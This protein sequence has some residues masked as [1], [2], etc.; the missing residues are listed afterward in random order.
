MP[1]KEVKV[2]PNGKF[3]DTLGELIGLIILML[4][5]AQVFG[6][7]SGGIAS[8]FSNRDAEGG[9]AG[10]GISFPPRDSDIIFPPRGIEFAFPPST[11]VVISFPPEISVGSSVV[12]L[13]PATLYDGP[14]GNPVG[15]VPAGVTGEV[16]GGP[17]WVDGVKWWQVLYEN[18]QTGWVTDG[19][20]RSNDT[21]GALGE[22]VS[23]YGETTVY[24][25][26]GGVPIGTVSADTE[27]EIVGGPRD[28]NGVRYWEVV[29]D[30]G[31][32]GWVAE[33]DIRSIKPQVVHGEEVSAVSD[34][35]V[36]DRPGGRVIGVVPEGEVGEIVGGPQ[37]KNGVRYYEVQFDDGTRGWVKES[38]LVSTSSN[39]VLGITLETYESTPLYDKPGGVV[40]G[41]VPVNT[42]GTVIDGP[43][44]YAGERY[45]KME[46]ENGQTGWVAE[47][48]LMPSGKTPGI[49]ARITLARDT[50]VYVTPG[51]DV[52]MK[53]DKG[54][55][56]NIIAG[57]VDRD[58]VR[59]W[60]VRFDDG[61]EA[62][63]P[64]SAL[65]SAGGTKAWNWFMFSIKVVSYILIVALLSGIMYIFIRQSQL[66]KAEYAK[67]W[68]TTAPYGPEA[69]KGPLNP[70]WDKIQELMSSDNEN[71]WR[72]AIMNADIILDEMLTKM[73]YHG[74]SVGEKLKRIEPSDF[75]TLN[76]A[77]E[78]HTVR[79]M[80]AHEKNIILTRREAER[81]IALFKEVFSEFKLL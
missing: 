16:V 38:D 68:D 10:F 62:W 72:I 61:T 42:K 76:Q 46:F 36:Y 23:P 75:T 71:D 6:A 7:I 13:Q 60:K 28:V 3:H 22:K 67:Y 27:G 32:R 21:D 66:A 70:E 11:P 45:W 80:L 18:G 74:E 58:G 39:P 44:Q 35:A 25:E 9:G 24:N 53:K 12:G 47:S 59:Y 37:D 49:G 34:T 1:D 14:N 17:E 81:V 65:S 64:E 77:W 40:I 43:V 2:D 20:L 63:V 69:E 19:D 30:D 41:F 15:T 51:G 56:G 73:G 33:D 52:L 5:L 29:F 4:I 78:A 54:D 26:P 8:R 50:D 31:T 57:P 79:N 55:M 48:L